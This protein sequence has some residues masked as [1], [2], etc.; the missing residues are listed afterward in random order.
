MADFCKQCTQKLFGKE[1]SDKLDM[2]I[3][4]D[5]FIVLLCEGCGRNVRVLNDGYRA[6]CNTCSNGYEG[7]CNDCYGENFGHTTEI[8]GSDV[9]QN[10]KR[11]I[12]G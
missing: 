4:K 8:A 11:R 5:E 12:N 1:L 10:F 9:C 6:E 7:V 2:G 3:K